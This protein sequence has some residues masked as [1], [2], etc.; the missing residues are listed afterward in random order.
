MEEEGCLEIAHVCTLKYEN[1]PGWSKSEDF[2]VK[3]QKFPFGS[4]HRLFI[5][6]L[7]RSNVAWSRKGSFSL[8]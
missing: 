4:G 7:R 6:T 8:P 5:N 1:G 2:A 3:V